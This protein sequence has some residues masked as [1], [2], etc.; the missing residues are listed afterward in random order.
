MRNDIGISTL[1]DARAAEL[2]A[3]SDRIWEMPELNYQEYRSSAEHAEMLE[4]QGFRVSTGK[5]RAF[6]PRSWAKPARAARSLRSWA[7]TTLF[8]D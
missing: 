2:C 4:R 7:N 8:P 5:S 3:L 1:V 6:R